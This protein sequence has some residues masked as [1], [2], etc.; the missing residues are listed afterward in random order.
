MGRRRRG[1]R[2]ERVG[3][4]PRTGDSVATS[5][6]TGGS[7]SRTITDALGNTVGT[8]EYAGTSPADATYGA[9]LVTQYSST[10]VTYTLDGK[11]KSITGPDSSVWSYTYDQFGR[12]RSATDPD[13]GT[14]TTSSTGR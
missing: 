12:L 8:R 14:S 7:A 11:Q 1:P 10:K 4:V 2:R 9:T 5:A 6:P 13:K 3:G